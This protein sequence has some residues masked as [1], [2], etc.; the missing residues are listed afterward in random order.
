MDNSVYW[1]EV[2]KKFIVKVS[3]IKHKLMGVF[4]CSRNSIEHSSPH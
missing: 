2:Y 3:K 4:S 1:S